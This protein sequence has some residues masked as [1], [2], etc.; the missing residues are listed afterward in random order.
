[1][2]KLID[3]ELNIVVAL[4]IGWFFVFCIFMSIAI[5]GYSV[6]LTLSV[7]EVDFNSTAFDAGLENWGTVIGYWL[8]II[9]TAHIIV[10][11]LLKLVNKFSEW[12]GLHSYRLK[13]SI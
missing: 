9:L 13:S 10:L 6:I 11:G 7:L 4:L 8:F 2:K 1:M 3:A 12:R 5:F